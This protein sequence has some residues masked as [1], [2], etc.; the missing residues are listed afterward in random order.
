MCMHDGEVNDLTC[1]FTLWCF[2]VV[3]RENHK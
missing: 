2:T 3:N 1:G